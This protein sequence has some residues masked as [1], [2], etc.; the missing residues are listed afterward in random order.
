MGRDSWVGREIIGS[1]RVA[2][3]EMLVRWVMVVILL[4]NVLI[5]Y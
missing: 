4:V 2:E 3:V 1:S 5:M